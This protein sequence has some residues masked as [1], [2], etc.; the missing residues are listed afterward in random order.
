MFRVNTSTRH[1]YSI[2]NTTYDGKTEMED[3]IYDEDY[4]L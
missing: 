3:F 2:V 4:E 1:P